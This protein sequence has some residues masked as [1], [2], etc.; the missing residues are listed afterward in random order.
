M[1]RQNLAKF[2]PQGRVFAGF[3]RDASPA[4]NHGGLGLSLF[5]G[6]LQGFGIAQQ[7]NPGL[8]WLRRIKGDDLRHGSLGHRRFHPFAQQFQPRPIT[9]PLQK[10]ADLSRGALSSA[11][12]V[13]FH[14][15]RCHR[16][17]GAGRQCL[18]LGPIFG[19][20]RIQGRRKGLGPG[21]CPRFGGARRLRQRTTGQG[22]AK[23]KGKEAHDD[24][25]FQRIRG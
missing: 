12:P 11:Q 18:S 3:E 4:C 16:T 25:R 10:R 21:R 17:T 5:P 2:R 1:G 7:S 6:G 8:R 14:Q 23:K 22:N 15:I 13:P 24:L 20:Y 9:A 19:S